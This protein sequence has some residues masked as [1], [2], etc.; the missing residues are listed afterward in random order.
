MLMSGS[1]L[2][3]TSQ[4]QHCMMTDLRACGHTQKTN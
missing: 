3:H 1:K 2:L 4:K